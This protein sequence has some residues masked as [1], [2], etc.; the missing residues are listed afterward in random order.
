MP[1]PLVEVEL[2]LAT[3]AI[4]DVGMILIVLL[5]FGSPATTAVCRRSSWTSQTLE[6]TPLSVIVIWPSQVPENSEVTTAGESEGSGTA[7]T[8]PVLISKATY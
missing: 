3:A 1:V 2:K 8:R 5:A 6:P 7:R 4:S